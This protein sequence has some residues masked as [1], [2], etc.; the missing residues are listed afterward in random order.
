MRYESMFL[1][2]SEACYFIDSL[3][4]SADYLTQITDERMNLNYPFAQDD[5]TAYKASLSNGA[6]LLKEIEYNWR[7]E[8]WG[9]GRALMT[10]KRFEGDK[11]RGTNHY[12]KQGADWSYTMTEMTF[13]IPYAEY[14]YNQSLQ[15]NNEE[16]EK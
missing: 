14:S 4:A 15:P 12:I 9:E 7:V 1:I 6:T 5:Y 8:M 10:F 16:T 11:K 3:A 2:A 13:D